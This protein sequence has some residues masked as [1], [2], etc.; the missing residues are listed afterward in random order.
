VRKAGYVPQLCGDAAYK[1]RGRTERDISEGL[2][3]P[4]NESP[5]STNTSPSHN[6]EREVKHKLPDNKEVAEGKT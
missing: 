5:N 3:L 4:G 1:G 6:G 2:N